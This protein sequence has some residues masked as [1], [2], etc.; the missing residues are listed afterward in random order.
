MEA[1]TNPRDMEVKLMFSE[2]A[3]KFEK[4]L[5]VLLTRAS[6]SV[7]ATAYLSKSRRRLL[8]TNVDKSRA[9]VSRGLEVLLTLFQP[10]GADFVHHIT[11]STPGFENLTTSLQQYIHFLCELHIV[12]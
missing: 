8:K 9:V 6:C 5:V 11:A 1:T 10:E 3:T 7:L 2:K 4:I 12:T